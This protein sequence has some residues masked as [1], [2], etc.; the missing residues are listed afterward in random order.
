MG[1][2][3]LSCAWCPSLLLCD[4]PADGANLLCGVC[5]EAF[6][7]WSAA[8]HPG[9][10]VYVQPYAAFRGAEHEQH[11][12]VC[13]DGDYLTVQAIGIPK[14]RMT[15]HVADTGRRDLTPRRNLDTPDLHSTKER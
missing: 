15:V 5:R 6:G 10:W 13:R 2:Q 4:D 1:C 12:I 14:S 9:D 7:Q 11:L 8:L 3:L